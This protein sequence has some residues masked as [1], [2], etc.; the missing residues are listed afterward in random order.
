[1]AANVSVLL[2]VT[3][4]VE[5]YI[6]VCHPMRG[7]VLCTPQR[8]K[9]IISLIAFLAV[10]CTLPEL[11]EM[12]PAFHQARLPCGAIAQTVAWSAPRSMAL[13]SITES[14]CAF[15]QPPPADGPAFPPA[16]SRPAVGSGQRPPLIQ[17]SCP[18]SYH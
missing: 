17:A 4:T 18:T 3:F 6:G 8:A 15:T 11:F 16:T 13:H 1:M 10:A 7:R 5:R 14:Q 9:V 12:E 2:T